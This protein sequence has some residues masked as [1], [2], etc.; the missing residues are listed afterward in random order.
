MG[1]THTAEN[2]DARPEAITSFV[3]DDFPVP[4]GREENW[5]FTPLARLRG[6]HDGTAVPGGAVLT[7]ATWAIPTTV[8]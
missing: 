1:V 6:L 4:N 7:G 8:A 5:R 3:V 2:V